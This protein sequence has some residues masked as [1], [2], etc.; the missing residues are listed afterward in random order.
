MIVER[1]RTILKDDYG[2]MIVSALIG[3]GIAALFK[4]SCDGQ[5]CKQYI[6]PKVNDIINNIWG[7]N[8]ECYVYEP[9]DVSCSANSEN[10]IKP[11]PKDIHV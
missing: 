5:M 3:L 11:S 9:K 7:F 4:K 2:S 10:I 6:A 8:G 1:F